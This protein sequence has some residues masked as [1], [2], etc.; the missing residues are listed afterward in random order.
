MGV[1]NQTLSMRL[2]GYLGKALRKISEEIA[3]QMLF[4]TGPLSGLHLPEH[5][6]NWS[7]IILQEDSGENILAILKFLLKDR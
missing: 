4:L 5:P 1:V 6:L 3:C 7:L 2:D